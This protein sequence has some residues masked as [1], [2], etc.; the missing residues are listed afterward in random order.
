MLFFVIDSLICNSTKNTLL[1]SAIIN[2]VLETSPEIQVAASNVADEDRRLRTLLAEHRVGDD[3]IEKS[4]QYGS[5]TGPGPL[6]EGQNQAPL[7]VLELP[8]A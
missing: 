4:L 1:A 7:G 8:T 6:L 3:S 5:A 2:D